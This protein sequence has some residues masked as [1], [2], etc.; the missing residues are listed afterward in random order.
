MHDRTCLGLYYWTKKMF[1]KFGWM[2][3]AHRDHHGSQLKLYVDGLCILMQHIDIKIKYLHDLHKKSHSSHELEM[4]IHD[5]QILH[6]NVKVLKKHAEQLAKTCK[7]A[8]VS[9]KMKGGNYCTATL[10][11]RNC[12]EC[13]VVNTFRLSSFTKETCY[14]R[15]QN[16][17]QISLHINR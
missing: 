10:L 7:I 1:E 2:I 5:M 6:D 16:C 13:H 15:C 9:K 17:N 12:S 3:L 8:K 4:K 11:N 14:Y